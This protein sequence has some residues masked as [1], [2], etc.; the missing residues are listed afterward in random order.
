MRKSP[1][2]RL[3]P[4]Y[5]QHLRKT[6]GTSLADTL[7]LFFRPEQTSTVSSGFTDDESI[8]DA[9]KNLRHHDFVTG[10]EEILSGAPRDAFRVA[11]FRA[12]FTRLLSER[13]QWMQ[14]KAENIAA[15]AAD[16]ATATKSLQRRSL[17]DILEAI[18]DHPV[19]LAG[20]WNHQAL[21]LGGWP[22]LR[23]EGRHRS[24]SAY[25]FSRMHAHFASGAAFRAW[26]DNNK[27]RILAGAMTSLKSLDYVGLT[28]DFDLSVREVFARIGLPEPGDVVVRN[29]RD[30]FDD[31]GDALLE[32]TAAPFLELDHELYEAAVERHAVLG[33]IARGTP[34]DYIGRVLPADR[35]L[36]VFSQEAPG[37]HGWYAAHQ[38]ADGGWARWSGPGLDSR[39]VLAAPPGRYRID[40]DVFG[41][42]SE[43]SL[44]EMQLHVENR[45][46]EI[47]EI[48][49]ALGVWRVSALLVRDRHDRFDIVFKIPDIG[50]PF[51]LE[52]KQISFSPLPPA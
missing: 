47:V 11:F 22:L 21:T 33:R 18:D 8:A 38:R 41:A 12:P 44:R 43:R 26:L 16:V 51:G 7:R 36:I 6:A 49:E 10:H 29:A 32:E 13:R 19:L 4:V 40:V 30:A 3:P 25:R 9:L 1:N 34:L 48:R 20:F 52:L 14:A 24:A 28:E 5:F 45:P 23:E 2:S 31:E 50:S 35:K 27:A 15:V 46:L 37:G 42:A 17:V 39:F